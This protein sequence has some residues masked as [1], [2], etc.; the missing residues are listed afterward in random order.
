MSQFQL[1][2]L[3]NC[4]KLIAMVDGKTKF[5][6]IRDGRWDGIIAIATG[7]DSYA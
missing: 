2:K 6:W 7:Y 4:S 1:R 3:I 5:V